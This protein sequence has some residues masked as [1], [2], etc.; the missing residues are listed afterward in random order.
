[1]KRNASDGWVLDSITYDQ[2]QV[3]VRIDS[4]VADWDTLKLVTLSVFD[5][6]IP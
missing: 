5:G 4:L 1:M 2:F 6:N 3:E